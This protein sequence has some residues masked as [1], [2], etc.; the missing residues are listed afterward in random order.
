MARNCPIRYFGSNLP[1]GIGSSYFA[2][3]HSCCR[4]ELEEEGPTDFGVELPTGSGVGDSIAGF[5]PRLI[6]AALREWAGKV[7]SPMGFGRGWSWRSEVW[8]FPLFYWYSIAAK[9]LYG[10]SFTFLFWEGSAILA[11]AKSTLSDEVILEGVLI[12]DWY[13]EGVVGWGEFKSLIPDWPLA[14]ILTG[15]RTIALR[16]HLNEE[17]GVLCPLFFTILEKS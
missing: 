14:T 16:A 6:E 8:S 4:R 13:L 3:F 17:V 12:H 1:M 7:D 10:R 9:F 15:P 11:Q 2:S 5:V